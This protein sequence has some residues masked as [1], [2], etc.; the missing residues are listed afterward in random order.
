MKKIQYSPWVDIPV[1][2]HRSTDS[3]Y[4]VSAKKADYGY[5][6][7][8]GISKIPV[9]AFVNDRGIAWLGPERDIYVETEVEIIGLSFP[10]SGFVRWSESLIKLDSASPEKSLDYIVRQFDEKITLKQLS[11][12]WNSDVF[13]D[14]RNAFN[15]WFFSAQRWSSE[16]GSFTKIAAVMMEEGNLRLAIENSTS[17][18]TGTV[19]IDPLSRRVCKATEGDEETFPRRV[20]PWGET[21][22]EVH[23]NQMPSPVSLRAQEAVY[24]YCVDIAWDGPQ[25]PY[26]LLKIPVV[27]FMFDDEGGAWVGPRQDFYIR[28]ALGII[29]GRLHRNH[30]LWGRSMIGGATEQNAAGGVSDLIH[31]FESQY[32]VMALYKAWSAGGD[33]A[34]ERKS[35]NRSIDLSVV[36]DPEFF[37]DVEDAPTPQAPD[38]GLDEAALVQKELES[39]NR[40]LERQLGVLRDGASITQVEFNETELRLN[41]S[42]P[43]W[44]RSGSVWIDIESGKVL[45]AREDSESK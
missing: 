22:I 9:L 44:N 12:A 11:N 32:D 43:H 17:G 21:T 19:W 18:R 5:G 6:V 45:K 39:R 40:I 37:K 1:T 7:D 41:I 38:S 27:A 34:L 4:E 14:L 31:L 13:T 29:G 20:A 8:Q 3:P 30:L 33:E 10:G 26:Y 36:F 2:V 28:T 15:P 24:G 42:N 35:P 23:R 16:P 25:G